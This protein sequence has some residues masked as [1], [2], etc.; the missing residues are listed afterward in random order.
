MRSLT[1]ASSPLLFPRERG[2]R[3]EGRTFLGG[4]L[5]H[6][7]GLSEAEVLLSRHRKK[8][9]ERQRKESVY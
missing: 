3:G 7:L 9:S 5:V 8:V 6:V 2:N 4:P 1:Q